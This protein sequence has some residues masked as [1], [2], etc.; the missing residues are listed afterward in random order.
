[1]GAL[2][3]HPSDCWRTADSEEIYEEP[4]LGRE[5][6]R[7]RKE[8]NHMRRHLMETAEG[9]WHSSTFSQK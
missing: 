2:R 8:R 3:R 1:R 6:E 9:V 5:L 4:K 7:V